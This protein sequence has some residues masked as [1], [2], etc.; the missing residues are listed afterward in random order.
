MTR[1][2]STIDGK[3]RRCGRA[4]GRRC[5]GPSLLSGRP[6]DPRHSPEDRVRQQGQLAGR[7]HFDDI[8][9]TRL[10]TA[11]WPRSAARLNADHPPT[12][13]Q[14]ERTAGR[15]R[16][17]A[18]P[19]ACSR[20]GTVTDEVT[21]RRPRRRARVAATHARIDARGLETAST[22]STGRYRVAVP[23]GR[24]NVLAE[25]KD[26][27]AIRAHRQGMPAGTDA[28]ERR[29]LIEGASSRDRSSARRPRC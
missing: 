21:D 16:R 12:T 27:V 8:P 28:L 19:T 26:R 23:E 25:A 7:F 24:Y 17:H 22:D 11:P 4:A 13:V 3:D 14:G 18:A 20:H 9:V 15:T 10:R 29:C 2:K 5:T 6:A 1:E